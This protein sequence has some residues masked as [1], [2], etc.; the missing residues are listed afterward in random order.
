M[1][2]PLLHILQH[3]LGLD[4]YGQGRQ[5]RNHY[6]AGAADVAKCRDLMALGYMQEHPPTQLSG[7]APIFAVTEVGMAA[8]TRESPKPPK[9][10]RSQIRYQEYLEVADCYEGFGD[11]LKRSQ[12]RARD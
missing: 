5:Y 4:G 7:G 2:Q 12:A 1:E 3:T 10:T 6:V 9:K 11:Y 8:V